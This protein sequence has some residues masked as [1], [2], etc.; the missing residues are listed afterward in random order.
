[1]KNITKKRTEGSFCAMI[2]L[3]ALDLRTGFKSRLKCLLVMSLWANQL[4]L[5][6]SSLFICKIGIIMAPTSQDGI[7]GDDRCKVL[8]KPSNAT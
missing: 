7:K 3:T 8:C 6:I 5:F 4:A 1:M 2:C